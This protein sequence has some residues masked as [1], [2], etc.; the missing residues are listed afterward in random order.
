MGN[1][2][3]L[4]FR[5]YSY[6][7]HLILCVFLLGIAFIALSSGHADDLKLTMLPWEGAKLTYWVLGLS[8]LGIL[9]ILLAVMGRFRAL[10][11]LWTLFVFVMMLRG[12]FLGGNSFAGMDEFKTVLWLTGGAFLAFLGSLTGLRKRR[13]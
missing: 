10:F 13:R 9:I 11:P 2:V 5:I 7:Y 4:I 6:L 8:L 1:A 12:F 3:S